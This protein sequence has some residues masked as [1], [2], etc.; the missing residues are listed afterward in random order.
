MSGIA[1]KTQVG[2]AFF[3]CSFFKFIFRLLMRF[4]VV[5]ER[6]MLALQDSL[7]LGS[8]VIRFSNLYRHHLQRP[9]DHT[10]V[11]KLA[12]DHMNHGE[13]VQ[14]SAFPLFVFSED[15]EETPLSEGVD[16]LPRAPPSKRFHLVSGQHR[17]AAMSLIIRQRLERELQDVV[18]EEDILEDPE[19]EWPAVIFSGGG[20]SPPVLFLLSYTDS[21][22]ALKEGIPSPGI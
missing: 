14:K 11:S 18:N 17:V 5:V 13:D 16:A 19:A 8:A 22:H 12:G 20:S 7:R 1:N 9:L 15:D 3:S 2:F 10:W 4:Y 21:T 6:Q